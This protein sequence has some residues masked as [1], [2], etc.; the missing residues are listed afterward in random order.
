MY[1]SNLY[2]TNTPESDLDYKTVYL[3]ELDK[4]LKNE[5]SLKTKSSSTGDN[6]SKNGKDDVD[7]DLI[8]LQVFVKD[9]KNGVTYAIELACA[10]VQGIGV[11]TSQF[12]YICAC[13]LA[14]NI[15]NI[16]GMIGYAYGQSKRFG[17]KGN[18]YK[19]VLKLEALFKSSQDY[20]RIMDHP[21]LISVLS[22]TFKDS[23]YVNVKDD[24]VHILN[25][26]YV[27]Q[28]K[29]KDMVK[30]IGKIVES[31][32]GRT[33]QNHDNIDWKGVSHAYRIIEQCIEYRLT[34]NIVFPRENAQY[35]LEIKQGKHDYQKIIDELDGLFTQSTELKKL[36]NKN[37]PKEF[38]EWYT[39]TLRNLY[40]L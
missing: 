34:G 6:N 7:S 25:K 16:D 18:R 4:L 37:V 15:K 36:E 22:E 39:K 12:R 8:P 32:G 14:F 40:N 10:C 1:G 13:L 17:L 26:R 9:F 23:E 29:I 24:A 28:E 11:F 27:F 30:Y 21:N 20:A 38:D 19:D 31:Y 33:I 5:S 3:P 35:L 2:G